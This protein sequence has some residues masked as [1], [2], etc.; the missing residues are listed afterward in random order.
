MVETQYNAC[1]EYSVMHTLLGYSVMHT[2]LGLEDFI[3][4]FC[5]ESIGR[6]S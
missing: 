4:F 3:V 2:L 6:L 5:C 1:T